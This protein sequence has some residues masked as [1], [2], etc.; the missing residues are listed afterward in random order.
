MI[1]LGCQIRFVERD[2]EAFEE[3]RRL[4]TETFANA[5]GSGPLGGTSVV[6]EPPLTEFAPDVRRFVARR[7]RDGGVGTSRGRRQGARQRHGATARCKR[8]RPLCG[9]GRFRISVIDMCI[10]ESREYPSWAAAV[11]LQELQRLEVVGP[12]RQRIRRQQQPERLSRSRGSRLRCPPLGARPSPVHMRSS[13]GSERRQR[14]SVA[15]AA[16]ARS[17]R[18]L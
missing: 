5:V 2:V 15:I 12:H 8:G 16:D 10:N 4:T 14:K 3:A 7:W 6:A 1:N 18:R 11:H 17:T 13:P 9:T